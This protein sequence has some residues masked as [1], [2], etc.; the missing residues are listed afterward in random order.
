S[1]SSTLDAATLASIPAALSAA[2]TSL[3]VSPCC[4]AISWTRFFEKRPP[5]PWPRPR[6]RRQSL[7]ALVRRPRRRHRRPRQLRRPP[8]RPPRA[9]PQRRPL[10]PRPEGPHPRPQPPPQR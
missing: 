1:S 8:P 9:R 3:L 5:N 10:P 4:L 6:I 7:R 2:R